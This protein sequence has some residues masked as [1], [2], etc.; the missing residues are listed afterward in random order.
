MPAITRRNFLT[1]TGG[2]GLAG[3]SPRASRPPGASSVRSRTSAGTTSR[4]PGQ[5]AGSRSASASPRTPGSRSRSTTSR[6]SSRQE[7]RLGSADP[8]RPRHGRDAHAL[9]R[10][11]TSR[12]WR[13]SGTSWASWRRSS[14][15]CSPRPRRRPRSTASG[16]RCP[17][18]TFFVCAYREDLFKKGNLK[19]PD[20]WEDLYTVGKE[21]KKMGHPVGIPISQNYDT[22]ST[23]VRCSGP[24]ADGWT[25]TARPSGSTRP[26]PS[27]CWSGIE[28][29]P[30][31]HG[32]RGAVLD[33]REQQRHQCGE[34]GLDPQPGQRLHRGANRKMV[35]ADGINHH[36]TLAG[37][38]GRHETDVP[39][40]IAS[41]SSRRTSS[42]PRSGSAICSARRKSTTS[43]SCRVMLSTWGLREPARSRGAEDRS[44]V[45]RAQAGGRAVPPLRLAGAAQRQGPAHHE[46]V[47]LPNMIAK[48]VTGTSTKEAMAWAEKEMK[49]IIAG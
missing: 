19:V 37:P 45:R 40:H 18:T 48:A 49:R 24:S 25:R 36:R 43:T 26:P 39:R 9:S 42:R 17:S 3:S 4:R 6:P 21:L 16:G 23:A 34:G 14:A 44:E 13:T 30:G 41:G 2:A 28:D 11:S 5:E 1:T 15:R 7:V 47:I 32:A 10:G 31:L 27:N 46:R 29:V 22:I 38:K 20:T 33:R 35:T 8:G 12:S